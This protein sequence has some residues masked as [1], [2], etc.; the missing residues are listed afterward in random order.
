MTA[1]MTDAKSRA[2]ALVSLGILSL[3]CARTTA[4]E[5]DVGL[6]NGPLMSLP[7]PTGRRLLLGRLVEWGTFAVVHT[8]ADAPDDE[9][10]DEVT[11]VGVIRK[12]SG[13]LQGFAL[14]N[15]APVWETYPPAP[16]RTLQ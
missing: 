14:A 7:E 9:L 13:R 11:G 12:R 8:V 16:C 6:T 4:A 3:A 10:T 15:G 5:H 1:P 2:A